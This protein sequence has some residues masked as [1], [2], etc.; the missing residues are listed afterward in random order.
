MHSLSMTVCTNHEVCV[1]MNS[2][3]YL[4]WSN[5]GHAIHMI[6]IQLVLEKSLKFNNSS[7]T[8]PCFI[9]WLGEYI[10]KSSVPISQL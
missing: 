1:H 9:K 5:E 3:F 2:Q 6:Y 10:N 7:A 8:K 4:G